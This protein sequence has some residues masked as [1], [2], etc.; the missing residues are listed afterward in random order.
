MFDDPRFIK[1]ISIESGDANQYPFS[2]DVIRHWQ[3]VELH[4]KVTYFVGENGSGKSTIAEALAITLRLNPEGGN[5]NINF[6]NLE[7]ES[8]L[9]Q[10]MQ[11]DL[12]FNTIKSAY[13]FRAESTFGLY[14]QAE[15]QKDVELGWHVYGWSD[16]HKASHGEGHLALIRDKAHGDVCIFDEPESALSPDRQLAFL[17]IIQQLIDNGSQVIICTHSPIVLS[18]PDALIYSL[19]NTGP[20]E[21][22]YENTPCVQ[23]LKMF[24]DNRELMVSEVLKPDE[25]D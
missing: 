4:P 5:R 14:T 21:V 15:K 13:F 1:R 12:G 17:A 23:F 7:S 11:V 9:H 20:Q 8:I 3:E 18:Y 16:R 24:A 19:E 25:E 10:Y 2:I 22:T 6:S